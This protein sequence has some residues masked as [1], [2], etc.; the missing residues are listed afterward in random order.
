MTVSRSIACTLR[1]IVEDACKRG[2]EA[3]CLDLIVVERRAAIPVSRTPNLGLKEAM[4]GVVAVLDYT[5]P[6]AEKWLARL[7]NLEYRHHGDLRVHIAGLTQT[8][9]ADA[10]AHVACILASDHSFPL[11]E[12]LRGA[13]VD[14]RM[15]N[16]PGPKGL[17]RLAGSDP[18]LAE[19]HQKHCQFEVKETAFG[20]REAPRQRKR[21]SFR[22]RQTPRSALQ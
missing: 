15:S 7:N 9:E 19:S 10:L 5:H 18:L 22:R 4:L 1:S 13:F 20:A 16:V 12:T 17:I 6:D 11:F 14:G 21:H 2:H 8:K 3:A